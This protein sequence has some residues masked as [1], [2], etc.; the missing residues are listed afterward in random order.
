M[1]KNLLKKTA[2][3]LVMSF[4]A[5]SYAA[6]NVAV[7]YYSKS[8]V[9]TK[10]LAES[11]KA[12]TGAELFRIETTEPYPE[13]YT[14]TTEV[15]KKEM[16]EGVLRPIKKLDIDLAK[17]DVLVIASPTWWHHIAGPVESWIRSVDLKDKFILTATTHGGGGVMETRKDFE[18]LLKGS[19]L[20]TQL[21]VFG[22]VDRE[23]VQVHDWL[24]E[25]KV[26][27]N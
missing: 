26:I 3:A 21:T 7:V 23:S 5:S 6:S 9:N 11:V 13:D 18:N 1:F 20:G 17:Y 10:S 4:A 8:G 22:S 24:K 15:V 25:N 12:F 16:D 2:I 14:A 27:E 19:K